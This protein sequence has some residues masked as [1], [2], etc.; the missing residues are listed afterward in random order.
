MQL[1]DA[2]SGDTVEQL[3]MVPGALQALEVA[4]DG[5]VVLRTAALGTRA[6]GVGLDG[7]ERWS[8]LGPEPVLVGDRVVV[9]ATAIEPGDGVDAGAASTTLR[10]RT[11][12]DAE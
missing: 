9:R 10:L 11:Y 5:Y 12:G 6:A 8:I 2:R 3:V 1:V 4:G 7:T